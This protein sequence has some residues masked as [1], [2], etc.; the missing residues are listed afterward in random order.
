MV[1]SGDKS[2]IGRDVKIPGADRRFAGALART[3]A[4]KAETR[5]AQAS[6]GQPCSCLGRGAF[7][8]HQV[9]RRTYPMLTRL[10]DKKFQP[11][12][13]A[14]S[15]CRRYFRE[16]ASAPGRLPDQGHPPGTLPPNDLSGASG[17]AT[18]ARTVVMLNPSLEI[19]GGTTVPIIAVMLNNGK[20]GA[21]RGAPPG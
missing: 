15:R 3:R 19:G 6:A 17:R 8:G 7:G 13:S 1:A 12:F 5:T 16:R 18:V 14:L 11:I 4:S 10:V 20:R 2:R 9:R 21:R